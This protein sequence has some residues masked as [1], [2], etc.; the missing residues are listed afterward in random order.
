MMGG[1]ACVA[2]VGRGRTHHALLPPP[3][4]HEIIHHRIKERRSTLWMRRQH[5]NR[6][7]NKQ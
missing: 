1:D 6:A 7:A 5:R 4:I 2:L 3:D